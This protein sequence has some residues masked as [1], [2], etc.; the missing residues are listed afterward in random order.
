MAGPT[1]KPSQ[2]KEDDSQKDTN[3]D[4]DQESLHC[5]RFKRFFYE[6]L[7]L[8]HCLLFLTGRWGSSKKRL[9]CRSSA[10]VEHLLP[11]RHSQSDSTFHNRHL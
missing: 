6:G 4:S 9:E 8:P 7:E 1:E 10:E 5:V 11:P 3:Q 2:C